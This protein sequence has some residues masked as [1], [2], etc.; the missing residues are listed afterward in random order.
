MPYL[1][2]T[3]LAAVLEVDGLRMDMHKEARMTTRKEAGMIG[4]SCV[5]CGDRPA[6]PCHYCGQVLC[7]DCRQPGIYDWLCTACYRK[8]QV[9]RA[10]KGDITR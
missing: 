8:E 3:A 4:P 7:D 9:E 6:K 2:H 5:T 10:R 1:L